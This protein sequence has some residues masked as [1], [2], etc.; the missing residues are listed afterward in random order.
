MVRSF[1]FS[2]MQAINYRCIRLQ[3]DDETNKEI[4]FSLL[5]S[6]IRSIQGSDWQVS[7]WPVNGPGAVA[8]S[9]HD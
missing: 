5:K 4:A 9:L 7:Q 6:W 1:C 3:S 8:I 2:L